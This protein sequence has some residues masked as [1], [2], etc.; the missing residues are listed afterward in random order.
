MA[1]IDY[2]KAF[3]SLEHNFIFKALQNQGVHT[4]IITI[5]K[6]IYP[7]PKS[8]IITDVT[9][10]YFEI[11]KSVR[12]GDPLFPI[13]FN[14]TLKKI[15]RNLHWESKGLPINGLKLSN[16]RFADDIVLVAETMEELTEMVQEQ[17]EKVKRA[18]LSINFGKSKVL[19]TRSNPAK[20]KIENKIEK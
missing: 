15:F 19:S 4:Q 16:L 12:Q 3:E 5:I 18:G 17:N 9:G 8:R 6:E 7:N 11:Q 10:P 1:F 13:L 20:V 2:N 14:T